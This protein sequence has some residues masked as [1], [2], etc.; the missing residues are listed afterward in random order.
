MR[1][2]VIYAHPVESSYAAALHATVLETLR[3]HH[4]VRDL[5]L[6]AEDFDPRLSRDERLQYH[7]VT[8]NSESVARYV[9]MLRWAEAVVFCF[10]V[11]SFGLPAILK[12]FFDRVLIPGV[13][14]DIDGA[15]VTPKLTHIAH[16][17]AVCT[18]GRGRWTV[19]FSIGDLPRTQ[20]SRYFRWF[21]ARGATLRYLAHYQMNAATERSRARFLAHVRRTLASI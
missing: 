3:A 14:F 7:D 15:R 2:L 10:P 17:I 19:R 6:Y 4:E 16:V 5:D 8:R 11:W 18:Y 9:E 12:G 1:I 20:I 21:C 13:A